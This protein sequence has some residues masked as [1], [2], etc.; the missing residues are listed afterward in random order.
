M[1]EAGRAVYDEKTRHMAE[2]M[3]LAEQ[4][5]IAQRAQEDCDCKEGMF[6]RQGL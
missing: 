4:R 1:K 3:I 2:Q 5:Q 6:P